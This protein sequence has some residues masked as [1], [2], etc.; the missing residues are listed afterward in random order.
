MPGN[1]TGWQFT[2]IPQR[3]IISYKI[4][5]NRDG[6]LYAFGGGSTKH[7]PTRKEFLGD[8]ASQWSEEKGAIGGINIPSCFRRKVTAGETISLHSFELSLAAEGIAL[9]DTSGQSPAASRLSATDGKQSPTEVLAKQAPNAMEWVL[10]P[11][12]R[13]VPED[14]RQNLMLLRE[15]LRDEEAKKPAA[16]AAPYNLGQ[17]LCKQLIATLNER[18]L[19]RVRVGYVAAQ[20]KANMG[21]ITNQALEARRTAAVGK[22]MAWPTYR[23]EKDQREEVRRQKENGAA[24]ENQRPILEWA[25]RSTAIR[26]DLDTLYAQFREAVRRPVAAP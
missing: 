5:V 19:A 3:V 12:D 1:L 25:D 9:E 4:R 23:R 22:G 21:E 7:P 8:D 18:D 15:D 17:E 14:I 2:S 11:L 24:L 10:A 16:N 20:A 26:K 13:A 6:V